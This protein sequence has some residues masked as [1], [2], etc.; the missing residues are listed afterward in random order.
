MVEKVKLRGLLLCFKYWNLLGIIYNA[1]FGSYL[2]YY[3]INLLIITKISLE[4]IPPFIGLIIGVVQLIINTVIFIK[5][6]K[7]I[8]IKKETIPETISQLLKLLLIMSFL[9]ATIG[10]VAILLSGQSFKYK[11]VWEI[12]FTLFWYIF[13][14]SYFKRSKYIKLYYNLKN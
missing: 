13:W 7:K 5:I 1:L 2:I 3:I 11:Y 9:F 4:D 12:V 8:N 6:L 10:L 14:T